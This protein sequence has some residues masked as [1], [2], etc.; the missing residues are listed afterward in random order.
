MGKVKPNALEHTSGGKMFSPGTKKIA[1]LRNANNLSKGEKKPTDNLASGEK[2]F[3]AW[4]LY[5][6]DSLQVLRLHLIDSPD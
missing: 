3:N 2:S 5:K 1:T 4:Y 6:V